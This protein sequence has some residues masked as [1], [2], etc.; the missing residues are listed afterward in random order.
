MEDIASGYTNAIWTWGNQNW[1]TIL[2]NVFDFVQVHQ[3]KDMIKSDMLMKF[4]PYHS[5]HL[6]VLLYLYF[7][8]VKWIVCNTNQFFSIFYA[9][10]WLDTELACHTPNLGTLLFA[11]GAG[12]IIHKIPSHSIGFLISVMKIMS[13]CRWAS[14]FKKSSLGFGKTVYLF[15]ILWTLKS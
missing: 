6:N 9:L 2:Y 5:T 13:Y 11:R 1:Y 15:P 14:C 8:H 12:Y 10:N 4:Q 3:C 7:L